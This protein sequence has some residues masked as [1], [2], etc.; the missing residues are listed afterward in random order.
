MPTTLDTYAPFDTGA[1][2]N[3]TEDTWRK[4]MRHMLG[5]A[6]GVI[7][8]FTS[9]FAVTGDGSG[10]NVKVATGECWI[11]GHYG[12][13]TAVKTL[14]IAAA[15]ATLGRLDRVVLRADFANN[16]VELDVLTGTAAASP[17]VRAVT[18]STTIWE[19]S[20]AIVTVPAADTSI[21]ANQVSDDRVYTTA[22]AK[23][24][25][26]A[27]V[28][29]N[30]PHGNYQ[31]VGCNVGRS[32]SGDVQSDGLGKLT[33]LRPGLWVITAWILFVPN[34]TGKRELILADPA[35]VSGANSTMTW[36]AQTMQP[37]AGFNHHLSV[38][39]IERFPA[40]QDIAAFAYQSSG[41]FLAITSD[42]MGPTISAVWVGP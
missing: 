37:S 8:G 14:P 20:L 23:Y 30:I 1:G 12:E 16:R 15:H 2:A 39:A 18:Q 3:V 10:M 7:R 17:V 41:A 35:G 24:G 21:A 5:S 28:D 22:Q 38:T 36:V 9:E 6:S 31:M 29:Q 40:N 4:F 25:R 33:L 42:G 19:T 26:A 32:L 11:R 13:S 34:G 27:G